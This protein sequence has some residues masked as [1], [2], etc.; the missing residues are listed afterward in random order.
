M[1]KKIKSPVPVL[2]ILDSRVSEDLKTLSNFSIALR[3]EWEQEGLESL[4][5]KGR[6]CQTLS[7]ELQ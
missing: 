3:Q 2:K 4:S 7:H 6:C 1:Q 5:P